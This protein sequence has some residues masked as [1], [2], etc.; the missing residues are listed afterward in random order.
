[1]KKIRP[2][3]L[4][5][6]RQENSKLKI[7]PRSL[8][9][10]PFP[11]VG[12]GASAGG[13]KALNELFKHLNPAL[14]MAYVLVMHLSPTH[15]S[16]LAQVI[17]TKTRMKVQTVTNGMEVIKNVIYVIPP[18]TFM[19]TVAGRLVL[20]PMANDVIGNLSIDYFLTS[21]AAIHKNNAI[22]VILSGTGTDGTLGLKAIKAEGGI[23]FAQD[24]TAEFNGMPGHAHE[25]GYVDLRLSPRRIADE[26]KKFASMPYLVL[27]SDQIEEVQS[28][29]IV[30]HEV[31]L[32]KIL[33]VVKNEKGVDFF[34]DYKHAS[35]FRRVMR[36]MALNKFANLNDYLAMVQTDHKEVNDLYNDFLVN[37]TDFFR[38]P[39]FYA[40]LQTHVFPSIVKNRKPGD[41]IRIWIAGCATGEEAYSVAI[42]LMEFLDNLGIVIPVNIFASDLDSNAIEKARLGVYPIS[43]LRSVSPTYVDKYF[44]RNDNYY[45]I[46]KAVRQVCIFSEHNLIKDPPFPRMDLVS[47]QNVLIYLN[48]QQHEKVLKTFHYV[49]RPTGFLF[50]GKSESV[51]TATDLF[52]SLDKR[53]KVYGRKATKNSKFNFPVDD[54]LKTTRLIERHNDLNAEKVIG[55]LML[56]QYVFPCLVVNKEF[57]I[58]QFFGVTS[59]YLGPGIGKASLNILKIIRE[60]LVT[61]IGSLLH[62]AK[63]TEK[64]VSRSGLQLKEKKA[65]FEVSLEV[66]P[67][68]IA[69]EIFFLVVFKSESAVA[70]LPKGNQSK[71]K[72]NRDFKKIQ[73]L[74]E[75]LSESRG[76][77]RST[78]EEYETTYEEL[79]ANNEEILSSNEELQSVN[80]E[81]EASKE[82]LLSAVDKL[83]S[84]NIEL[85]DRNGQ[86]DRSQKELQKVNSQ[87]EQFAFIS[88][89]DLQEPMRKIR[90]LSERLLTGQPGINEEGK[91]YAR[92]LGAS[93]TRMSTLIKDLL[94]FSLL[95]S[96]DK[97]WV[98]VDLNK[99]L[100]AVIDDFETTIESKNVVV[101]VGELPEVV[102]ESFQINQLFHHLLDN[103]L[104]F[105]AEDP[106]ISITSYE[107]GSNDYQKYPEL[108]KLIKYNAIKVSDNGIG[109]DETYSD[110]IFKLFQQLRDTDDVEGTGVGLALCRKI[111]EAHGGF[112]YG[113]GK[114]GAGAIFIVFLPV[115]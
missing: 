34:R 102:G 91:N 42:C 101:T 6:G 48:T 83:T 111:A 15:K 3:R 82:E 57:T 30:E 7:R 98:Q 46:V 55:N 96:N 85:S 21:L 23:T 90:I 76:L 100:S 17:Q 92:K 26:L 95:G 105:S 49:L 73:K 99:I 62:Q 110:R 84:T 51:G 59:P 64:P 66:V 18:K 93:A 38:D 103:A 112:L 27:P 79:Q 36:R 20:T 87:L 45:Q 114:K 72:G 5:R 115:R 108:N 106:H 40:T 77:V 52:E 12:I 63:A 16:A 24:E 39:D 67:K 43:A 10:R 113:H 54:G 1:M 78:N 11:I 22:G 8:Q 4:P 97:L 35:V 65:T 104:K 107:I 71:T 28:K 53:I 88:S 70:D 9:L 44:L 47:C 89:H 60:E 32:Q 74:E 41:A 58:I 56:S 33:A 75:E 29:E 109:F 37:V 69:G 80:E 2:A 13:I 31:E 25:S 86:L 61:D 14:G 81:L 94:S 50:L 68:K 19:T